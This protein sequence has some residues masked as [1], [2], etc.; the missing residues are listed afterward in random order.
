[1]AYILLAAYSVIYHQNPRQ[2][3][4]Y[5]LRFW[6]HLTKNP[7]A[8]SIRRTRYGAAFSFFALYPKFT[9]LF[10]RS[11][12]RITHKESASSLVEYAKCRPHR[13]QGA[14]AGGKIPERRAFAAALKKWLQ[15]W[16]RGAVFG[17]PETGSLISWRRAL[18]ASSRCIPECPCCPV[19][20]CNRPNR[21]PETYL[22]R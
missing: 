18:S 15:L 21:P 13:K 2:D 12:G 5:S 10:G 20:R 22:R 7:A 17:R 3:T 9:R 4:K 14:E 19:W 1:M 11:H 6:F 16:M 8:H